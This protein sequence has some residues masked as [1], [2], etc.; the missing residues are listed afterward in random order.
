[1]TGFAIIVSPFLL[2]VIA[3]WVMRGKLIK[4]VNK[5]KAGEDG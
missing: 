2:G 5:Q 3:G 4:L 1:M